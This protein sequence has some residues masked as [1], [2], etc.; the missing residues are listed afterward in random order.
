M[1]NMSSKEKL[2]KPEKK[3]EDPRLEKYKEFATE[4]H[5]VTHFVGV[6]HTYKLGEKAI[7]WCTDRFKPINEENIKEFE[8]IHGNYSSCDHPK[9]MLPARKHKSGLAVFCYQNNN[10]KPALPD[11]LHARSLGVAGNQ[12]D[13]VLIHDICQP[14]C[15]VET[16][17]Q[18]AQ[19]VIQQHEIGP[20]PLFL[21]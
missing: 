4:D 5:Y 13:S 21:V 12:H 14:F 15:N 10:G 6:P 19:H 9:C 8:K 1:G 18:I 2:N 7:R 3:K 20:F 11:F 17:F 16:C